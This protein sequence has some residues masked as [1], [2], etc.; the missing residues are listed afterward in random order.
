MRPLNPEQIMM[1][2]EEI[3]APRRPQVQ[4]PAPVQEAPRQASAAPVRDLTIV[5]GIPVPSADHL[6]MAG[7]VARRAVQAILPKTPKGPERVKLVAELEALAARS[8]DL[9][10]FEKAENAR[11]NFAGLM[12]PMAEALRETHP[13]TWAELEELA[14]AKQDA[15]FRKSAEKRAAK[16]A[17]EREAGK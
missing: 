2:R 9:K 10:E 1:R 4:A 5:N 17:A 11:R 15:I 6:D 12:S 7:V 16:L 3:S 8:R 13:E 14:L